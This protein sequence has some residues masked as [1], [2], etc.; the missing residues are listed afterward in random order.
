[1]KTSPCRNHNMAPLPFVLLICVLTIQFASAQINLGSNT[2]LTFATVA[3]G[4]QVLTNRDDFIRALS[5]FDRAARVKTDKEVSETEFLIFV[6]QHNLEWNEAERQKVA[7]ALKPLKEKLK[8]LALPF[9]KTI[10][11]IKTSGLE[12]S[13]SPYTRANAV[14]LPHDTI[15][16]PVDKFRKIFVHE[17]FHVLSRANPELKERLYAA[18]GFVKCAE[19]EFPA[20]LKARNF[21]NPDAP[22]NNHCILLKTGGKEVW[23]IPILYSRTEKYDTSSDKGFFSYFQFRLL[24][25]DRTSPDGKPSFSG[26]DQRLIGLEET[27]GFFEQI[28][29]NTQ[30]IIHPEEILADNFALWIMGSTNA[31]SPAVLEKVAEILKSGN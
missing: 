27:T 3:E 7:D 30:Y 23:A 26:P 4:R 9:P 14:I 1:M 2:T 19:A 22:A 25:A 8:A 28:G 16:K 11:L 17:L 29:K 21:T 20:E 18:I 13:N 12:D 31:P 15:A 5:P 6:G 24:V 10:Q